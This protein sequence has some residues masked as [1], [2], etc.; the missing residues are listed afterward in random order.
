VRATPKPDRRTPIELT[1]EPLRIVPANEASWNDLELIF[2]TRGYAS[3]CWC[4]RFKAGYMD[5]SGMPV[6]ERQFQLRM[7]TSCDDP[8]AQSTSGLVAFLG[9]EP[10]GWCAVEPRSRYDR[11]KRMP[12]PWKD[13]PGEDR[14]DESVWAVTC[15]ATRAGFRKRGISRALTKATVEYARSRGARAL[16]GYPMIT[17][18]GEDISWGETFVGSRGSFEAA[19]FREI[20]RPSLRRVVMRIDF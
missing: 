16:E 15:F 12:L 9:D 4:R 20:G 17:H 8:D 3:H 6:Y 13:R 11:L 19:G 2:G 18:P 1:G 14:E 7:E 5:G 10:V